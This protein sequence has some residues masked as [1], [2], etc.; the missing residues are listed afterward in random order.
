MHKIDTLLSGISKI[1]KLST[2][3]KQCD[4]VLDEE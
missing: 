3:L 2:L 1:K 4:E